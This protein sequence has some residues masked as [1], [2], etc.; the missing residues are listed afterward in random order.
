MTAF[1]PMSIFNRQVT[2][3]VITSKSQL[4]STAIH[5]AIQDIYPNINTFQMS[6]ATHGAAIPE[7][8]VN[9]GQECAT[10]RI[11]YVCKKNKL[12]EYFM[13]ISVENAIE[14]IPNDNNYV[15]DVC[16]VVIELPDKSR[17]N[18][19]SKPISVDKKYYMMAIENTPDDYYLKNMGLS[20][21]V[22]EMINREDP[23]INPKQWMDSD[24]FGGYSRIKQIQSALVDAI[25]Q[26][27][28][29]LLKP[30]ILEFPNWPKQNV[31]F[32]D[33]SAVLA[34]PN[35]FTKLVNATYLDLKNKLD[36]K[37]IDKIIG[38]DS[39]GFIY[40]PLLAYKM[41]CGFV[42]CR[43]KGKLP[44]TN[45]NDIISVDYHTEYSVDTF[46]LMSGIINPGDQ[47]LIVDDL[48]ATGGSLHAAKLLVETAHGIVV[49]CYTILSVKDLLHPAQQ[50]LHPVDIMTFF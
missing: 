14:T 21:T 4:K 33:L 19:S 34:D 50:M 35:M 49:G 44:R 24:K 37:Q 31:I 39:R 9:T 7:Q 27:D 29:C 16:H 18:G 38:L 12:K 10:M 47:I 30:Q 8:P 20:T 13:I 43:K 40:G 36:G 2:Q 46:E 6:Y 48:V 3:I 15:N 28:K 32:K 23:T 22:G 41:G 17:Y 5:L 26:I 45:D 11:E 25:V 1:K 42:M